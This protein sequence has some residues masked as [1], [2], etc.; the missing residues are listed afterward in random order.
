MNAVSGFGL[1]DVVVLVLV[2]SSVVGALAS[3]RGIFGALL[4][5]VG[6]VLFCWLVALGLVAWAPG[7]V[8]GAV[9]SSTFLQLLPVPEPAITQA[10]A[11]GDWFA[12]QLDARA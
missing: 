5:G 12:G 8:R 6:T 9:E 10:R 7:A 1:V 3:R 4:S 2:V 11:L